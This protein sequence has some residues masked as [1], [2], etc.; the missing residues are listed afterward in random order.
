MVRADRR[1]E[2]GTSSLAVCGSRGAQGE[3]GA[4]LECRGMGRHCAQDCAAYPD[5]EEQDFDPY[6]LESGSLILR[7]LLTRQ[8]LRCELLLWDLKRC[9]TKTR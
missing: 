7:I 9:W 6:A 3:E 8:T 2:H 5:D 1:A 4:E